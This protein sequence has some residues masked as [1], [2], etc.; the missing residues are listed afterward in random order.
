MMNMSVNMN[1]MNYDEDDESDD[2]KTL[3]ME[4]TFS[5]EITQMKFVNT[6]SWSYFFNELVDIIKHYS[7]LFIC[8][9]LK[10]SIEIHRMIT[11]NVLNDTNFIVFIN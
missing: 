2:D 8:R 1:T 3:W 10:S 7:L 11:K 4:N 6:F 9:N 5:R